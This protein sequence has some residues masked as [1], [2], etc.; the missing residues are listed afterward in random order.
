MCESKSYSIYMHQQ[1][2]VWVSQIWTF[3]NCCGQT[4]CLFES[5]F[6]KVNKAHYIQSTNLDRVFILSRP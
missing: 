4:F 2:L 5:F 3:G 1:Q 6:Q